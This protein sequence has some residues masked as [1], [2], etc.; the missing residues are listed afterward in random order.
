ML[1][2]LLLLFLCYAWR[3]VISLERSNTRWGLGP[4]A[5]RG[6][7]RSVPIVIIIAIIIGIIIIIDISRNIIATYIIINVFIIIIIDTISII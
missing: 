2:Y 7:R 1:F 4:D 5:W 6:G 3:G